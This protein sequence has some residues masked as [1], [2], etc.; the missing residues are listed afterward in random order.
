MCKSLHYLYVLHT[1]L[2]H[3]IDAT[4]VTF[5]GSISTYTALHTIYRYL[6]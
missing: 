6:E 1:E 3:R 4:H 5:L 2:L